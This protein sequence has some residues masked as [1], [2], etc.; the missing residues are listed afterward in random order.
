MRSSH[1][2]RYNNCA[3]LVGR[4]CEEYTECVLAKQSSIVRK[5]SV[6]SSCVRLDLCPGRISVRE[7]IFYRGLH[8]TLKEKRGE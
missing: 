4:Q 6:V 3:W 8:A 1:E 2:G 7:I 5:K